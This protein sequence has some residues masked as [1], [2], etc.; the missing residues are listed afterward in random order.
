MKKSLEPQP[1]NTATSV[2]KKVTKIG[3]KLHEQAMTAESF[4]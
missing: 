4:I 3:D 1:D 2:K